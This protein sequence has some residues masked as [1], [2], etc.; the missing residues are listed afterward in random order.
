MVQPKKK[1]FESI[2]LSVG[3]SVDR[4]ILAAGLCDYGYRRCGKVAEEGDFA[5]RGGIIDI[6]PFT[7]ESP[8]R[9]ET[10]GDAITLIK[11]FDLVSDE[12]LEDH[13]IVILLPLKG[14]RAFRL[15]TEEA[16]P[17]DFPIDSF[18]DLEPGDHIVHVDHGIGIFRG[19]KKMTAA[20]KVTEHVEVEYADGDRLYVPYAE[21][22]KIQKYI[23]LHRRPPRLYRLG[24]KLWRQA[25]RRAQKGISELAVELL[26]LQAKR[27]LLG[28]FAF[29]KD[30]D[31]QAQLEGSFPY[32]ETKDQVIATSDVKKDMESQRPM[33]RLLCGDVGYGKTEV[34]LRAA[35]KAMMDNRQV[36]ILVPTTILA[37]QHYKTFTNRLR[38]FPVNVAMLSRFRTKAEQGRIAKEVGDGKI[39]IIIGTHRLLSEDVSFKN[40]G[41]VIIDEEQRFGVKHK[42]HLKGL[43][44]Q[45]DVLTLTATP[46]PRTLYLS[47]MG[48]RDMSTINTPPYGRLP[49]ETHIAERNPSLLRRVIRRELRRKGQVYFIHNRVQT[50]EKAASEVAGLVPKARLAVGHGQMSER[51][52]E[53]VMSKFMDGG[54]DILVST[55]IV[56]SGIDIPNANTIIINRADTFGLAD[57]Y[58]L[59]GRVGRF[60]RNAYAYL[61]VPNIET[62]TAE[63]QRRLESMRK[64]A[65]LGSGFKLAMKDLE[66][67]GAGNILG[68]EQHG[69]IESIGF[70]LYCRLLRNTVTTLKPTD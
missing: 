5:I 19:M 20:G 57:L 47:L 48:A 33:D 23:G 10:D 64:F 2:R 32:K 11:G 13:R 25:K 61:L 28:G 41:L 26:Q 34:A 30:S 43:R 38:E 63:A 29:S 44:L 21:L 16:P 22:N 66:L 35:F 59:R 69:Y 52:L 60:K 3:E 68:D 50:I 14:S 17:E 7:F 53:E 8:L 1:I 37:E 9:V 45:A 56:E 18:V 55:T 54:I 70:D 65:S 27:E 12:Y 58:Q 46:I 51:A 40:L 24:G 67:R 6:F 31:W 36:A 39:D 49:I 42:E 62:L 4:D 15:K